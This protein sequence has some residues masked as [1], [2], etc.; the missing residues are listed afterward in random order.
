VFAGALLVVVACA[1]T[2]ARRG[3][4]IASMATGDVKPAGD[5]SG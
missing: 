5:S 1:W 3:Q 4:I 2:W